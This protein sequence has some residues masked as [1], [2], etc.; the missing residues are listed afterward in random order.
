[1]EKTDLIRLIKSLP[2]AEL[3]VHLEGAVTPK[4]LEAL[5]LKGTGQGGDR[6]GKSSAE[7]FQISSRPDLEAVRERISSRLREP[8]DYLLALEQI[9]RNMADQNILYSEVFFAPSVRW[10]LAKDAEEVLGALLDRSLQVEKEGGPVIRWILTCLKQLGPE[11]TR[12]TVDLAIR[13]RERGVV[14]VGLR[15]SS[16]NFSPD[17]FAGIFAWAKVQGLYV[18]VHAG[19][20]DDPGEVGVA[21]DSLGANRIGHGFQASRDPRLMQKL[22]NRAVGLDIC[23]KGNSLTGTWK[24]TFSH[25]FSLLW[26]RGVPLSLSTD[27]PGIFN[28]SLS[29]ELVAAT[30][31]FQLSLSDLKKLCLMS[32]SLSF[33]P[34]SRKMQLMQD[35]GDSIDE[36]FTT[37]K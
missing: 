22:R 1:M 32:V 33:L 5:E 3:H 21:L 8:S 37:L 16:E 26:K 12:K 15:G 9:H 4:A 18:H 28:C 27:N 30:E 35:F 14:A 7:A 6:G 11:E 34:Y 20:N 23:L 10:R 29:E 25:P 19:E 36:I 13:N 17:E 2:K 31:F 24:H